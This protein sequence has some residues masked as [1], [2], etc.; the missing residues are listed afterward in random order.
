LIHFYKRIFD[1][2]SP[3]CD[4]AGQKCDKGHGGPNSLSEINMVKLK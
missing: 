4:G 1:K 3:E 2:L